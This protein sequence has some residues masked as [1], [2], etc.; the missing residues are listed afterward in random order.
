MEQRKED[1]SSRS[2]WDK[3]YSTFDGDTYEWLQD[4]SVLKPYILR[5]TKPG[6]SFLDVGCGLSEVSDQV[7]KLGLKVTNIDLSSRCLEKLRAR[8]EKKVGAFLDRQERQRRLFPTMDN[9][10]SQ[11]VVG[12]ET[13]HRLRKDDNNSNTRKKKG[14]NAI[15]KKHINTTKLTA[16][17]KKKKKKKTKERQ[18]QQQNVEAEQKKPKD[19]P[20]HQR[21]NDPILKIKYRLLDCTDMVS[22]DEGEFDIVFDKGTLDSL[23][24]RSFDETET[25]RLAVREIYRVLKPGGCFILCSHG[26]EERR[27]A[28]LRQDGL[29]WSSI[30]TISLAKKKTLYCEPK[31]NAGHVLF[32]CTRKK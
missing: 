29:L 16:R 5:K 18:P 22:F 20:I 24:C 10:D 25:A 23:V 7:A 12:D 15:V 8:R 2:Y 13:E 17:R 21:S 6:Q 26:R 3:F 11:K 28:L 32:L 4:F 19:I 27:M 14:L 1:F 30:Q 9:N 31:P